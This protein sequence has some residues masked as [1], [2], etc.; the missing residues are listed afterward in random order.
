MKTTGT[1]P[2]HKEESKQERIDNDINE[3]CDKI[4]EFIKDIEEEHTNKDANTIKKQMIDLILN[5]IE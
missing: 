1:R 3:Y 4:K 5:T 2:Y